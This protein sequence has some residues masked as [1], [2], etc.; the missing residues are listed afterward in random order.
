MNHE[1]GLLGVSETSSNMR[2]V[3]DRETRNV[4]AAG[5]VA[6]LLPG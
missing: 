6:D 3:L 2:D 5:A 1:L 4:R